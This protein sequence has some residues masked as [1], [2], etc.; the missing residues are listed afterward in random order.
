[1][2]LSPAAVSKTCQERSITQLGESCRITND[3][4][5]ACSILYFGLK[6][7]IC[8]CSWIEDSVFGYV[9]DCSEQQQNSVILDPVPIGQ[10]S[11]VFVVKTL[12]AHSLIDTKDTVRCSFSLQ[13]TRDHLQSTSGSEQIPVPT[14]GRHLH[15]CCLQ[16]QMQLRLD[17][18]LITQ[19]TYQI[20]CSSCCQRYAAL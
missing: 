16:F 8:L 10:T 15:T 9:L 7:P 1:M 18:G 5:A 13:E 14:L 17:L 19:C 3:R 12:D 2:R 4:K 11:L 6:Q 20:P